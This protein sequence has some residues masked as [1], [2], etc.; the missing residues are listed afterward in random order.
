MMISLSPSNFVDVVRPACQKNDS[1]SATFVVAGLPRGQGL[2]LLGLVQPY[3]ADGGRVHYGQRAPAR[4]LSAV[5][6]DSIGDYYW[7]FL[8]GILL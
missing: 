5:F 6:S 1:H 7:G 2:V 3:S 4:R 8:R